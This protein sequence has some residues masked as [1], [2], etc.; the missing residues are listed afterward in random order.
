MMYSHVPAIAIELVGFTLKSP[1]QREHHFTRARRV[2]AER[3]AVA[4]AFEA[5]S[6]PTLPVVVT[7]TRI[8]SRALDGHDNLCAAFKA[9]ADETARWLGVDDA[10]RRMAWCYRQ[11]PSAGR[12]MRVPHYVGR[13]RL[14]D[15]EVPYCAVRIE[16]A[17]REVQP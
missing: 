3:A 7:L 14:R 10:D 15:R 6:P 13:T 17:P 16:I 12:R 2:R 8:A 1:N 4:H 5:F 11:E 9:I